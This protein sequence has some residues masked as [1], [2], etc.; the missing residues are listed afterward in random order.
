[1]ARFDVYPK[2]GAHASTTP[3][4]LVTPKMGSVPKRVLKVSVA[5][6]ADEQDQITGAMDFLFHGY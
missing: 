3:Y 5:C 2:P 4:L 1:M 6:L